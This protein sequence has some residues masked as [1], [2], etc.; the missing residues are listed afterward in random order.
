MFYVSKLKQAT[1]TSIVNINQLKFLK[2][3]LKQSRQT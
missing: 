2:C 1:E 3:A